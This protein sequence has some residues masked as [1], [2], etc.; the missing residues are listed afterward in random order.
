VYNLLCTFFL[1]EK[2]L[3]LTFQT[4]ALGFRHYVVDLSN[5]T[6]FCDSLSFASREKL[7][8]LA[9]KMMILLLTWLLILGE[10]TLVTA[11]DPC[12]SHITEVGCATAFGFTPDKRSINNCGWNGTSCLNCNL[13]VTASAGCYKDPTLEGLRGVFECSVFDSIQNDEEHSDCDM[14]FTASG[15][16]CAST[17]P[18]AARKC[19][20]CS[21]IP[22]AECPEHR[23]RCVAESFSCFASV[24]QCASPDSCTGDCYNTGGRCGY[25]GHYYI[26]EECDA[27]LGCQFD[28]QEHV[29]I[30]I[31]SQ[32]GTRE[33][34]EVDDKCTYLSDFCQP[35]FPPSSASKSENSQVII[36]AC[37][38]TGGGVALLAFVYFCF[39]QRQKVEAGAQ[40][41]SF[42]LT[43]KSSTQLQS[44]SGSSS[45]RRKPLD[46][47]RI[48]KLIGRGANG[49]IYSCSLADGSIFCMYD[50]MLDL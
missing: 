13:E 45:S 38:A 12:T 1:K 15:E 21:E 28:H 49:S 18:P 6:S 46:G 39:R 4:T 48:L 26:P 42:P 29:C 44:M 27:V 23:Q 32:R 10:I 2:P 11:E 35:R 25:C 14:S 31:C 24:D 33:E 43:L 5:L 50:V 37:C 30:G 40:L 7:T 17:I 16:L 41:S 22:P 20:K 47:T 8:T 3:L 34:C 19:A 9:A 36:I